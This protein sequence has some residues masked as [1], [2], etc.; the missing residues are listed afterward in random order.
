MAVNGMAMH[1]AKKLRR[2]LAGSGAMMN[3]SMT[4][5]PS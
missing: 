3:G 1:A 4:G 5:A 2:R